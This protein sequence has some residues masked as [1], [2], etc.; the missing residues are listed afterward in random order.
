MFPFLLILFAS[1]LFLI[2]RKLDCQ[3]QK[4]KQQNQPITRLKIVHGDWFILLNAYMLLITTLTAM[5]LLVKTSLEN[6]TKKV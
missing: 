1:P 5:L 3:N 4:Q 2:Q 6:S